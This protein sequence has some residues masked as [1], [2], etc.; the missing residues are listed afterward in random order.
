ME[1]FNALGAEIEKIWRA[2]NYDESVFPQIA[3]DGLQRADLTSK[4]SAWDVAEW[5]LKEINLPAQRDLTGK[6]GDPPIT[7]YNALRFHIDVYFWL[8]GTTSIHQHAFCGAFQV[9]HG[10]S[11]HSWY[12]FEKR[13]S[14]NLFTEIGA[15]TLK[16]CELLEI[17]A[18]QKINAGRRY[19]HSLFHLEQP[20]ATIVVRTHRSPL[21]MP[22]Y[23]YFKPSL[24]VY[25]QFEEPTTTKKLQMIS[26][27]MRV[28]HP[29]TERLVGEL[30][31]E[32][33]F[34]TTFLI[35]NL[36]RAMLNAGTVEQMFGVA[37]PQEKFQS[38]LE[39]VAQKHGAHV[40]VLREVYARRDR[41]EEIIRRRSFVT[42]PE[43]RFFLAL[44]LNVE[45]R[46][47]IF[48]LI[49]QR[50]PDAEPLDKTLDWIFDLAQTRVTGLNTPNALGIADFDDFDL[51]VL[52]NLL[53]D[54]S[55]DR[56]STQ[57]AA[58][59]PAE[60]TE[61]LARKVGQSIEKIRRAAIFQ[62]LLL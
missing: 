51:I 44:L 38:F 35:L 1:V 17:G 16:K 13:E 27:L 25:T 33:D 14:I 60:T 43:H 57:I 15:M 56:I 36:V 22:Q 26:A 20:S 42:E 2:R 11:I 53:Q 7:I 47:N 34:Q 41:T 40:E 46:E 58:E 52:E 48:S 50:F 28:K 55:A 8:E 5:T 18:I 59:F 4:I 6:F 39:I 21:E 29:Q 32:S 3:A 9:L 30:L 61:D 31:A 10:A 45:G 24:A 23:D 37:S 19:I 54:Q 12:D 49:K 62:P